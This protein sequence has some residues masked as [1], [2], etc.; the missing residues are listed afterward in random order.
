[1][2]TLLAA[3]ALIALTAPV[4]ADPVRI[5][6]VTPSINGSIVQRP[7]GSDAGV[8]LP[9][10]DPRYADMTDKCVVRR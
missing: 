4:M 6:V 8:S 2:K 10:C 9:Y 7:L 3:L 1:M 5:I